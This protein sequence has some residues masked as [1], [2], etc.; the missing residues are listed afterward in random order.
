MDSYDLISYPAMPLPR[1]HPNHL[2][3]LA[4]L[5]GFSPA[6]P[7]RCRILEL[8]CANGGNLIPM[9]AGL[10][11]ATMVG[12][13]RSRSQAE[14][15]Q[16]ILSSLGLAN[17]QIL[18]QDL[19]DYEGE[20]GSFDYILA[21]G[22]YSWVPAPV[23]QRIME[24]C[25]KLLAP[26]GLAL[27]SFNCLPGWHVKGMLREM[28][29]EH[30]RHITDPMQRLS[31]AQD[32]LG[33]YLAALEESEALLARH[34]V[35]EIRRLL[36]NH[37]AYLYHEYLEEENQPLLFRTFA[38][39]AA[40]AGLAPLC[41]ADAAYWFPQSMG[42]KGQ[43]WLESL[44]HPLEQQQTLDFLLL[45][46]FRETV[47]CRRQMDIPRQLQLSALEELSIFASLRP[48]AKLLLN[49][50]NSQFFFN[51]SGG[52]TAIS[53][54]LTRAALTLLWEFT[55]RA[56]PWPHLCQQASALV[57]RAGNLRKAEEWDHMA[58][59]MMSLF[60]QGEV[61]LT[62]QGDQPI[63]AMAPCP[64]ATPLAAA[65]AREGWLPTLRHAPLTLDANTTALFTLLDGQRN[66]EELVQ[67][68]AENKDQ[69]RKVRPWL[70]EQ[71]TNWH[72]FGVLQGLF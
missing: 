44:Q 63:P 40:Q 9:A 11:E 23:R 26:N 29:L 62:L 28:V 32:F 12:I 27:I 64:Q 24:L 36:T 34:L 22:L 68:L 69:Q 49:N 33:D 42:E 5:L 6:A 15:G 1:S 10:P 21:H 17:C 25:G 58:G 39:Q 37:P 7:Q 53:H 65:F 46:Q 45:R 30:C 35:V 4:R 71:L 31:L 48:P 60:L 72:R 67:A 41:D 13:E 61:G 59:E 56:M 50:S 18:H 54:P 55:P 14:Q 51:H 20:A 19:L 70:E 47:L 3:A 8:G 38:Q 16:R 57:Q 43:T 52:K 2:A 66:Q